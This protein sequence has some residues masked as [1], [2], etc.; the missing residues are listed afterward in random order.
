MHVSVAYAE[1]EHQEWIEFEAP[2]GVTA[3]EAIRLSGITD[4]FPHL[5]PDEHKLGVF[6]KPVKPDQELREGDR[7]EI[8]RPLKADPKQART[9]SKK[10]KGE[11]GE[12][13]S[14]GA[15]AAGDDQEA[16]S[17]A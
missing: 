14:G 2:E 17:G 13:E 8:Y 3:R 12:G 1:P 4:K 11:E 6:G 9:R 10:S 16:G 5:D 15:E 7:V